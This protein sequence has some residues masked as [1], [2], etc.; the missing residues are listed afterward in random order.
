MKVNDGIVL[1][2]D[3][4]STLLGEGGV[5]NVYNYAHKIFNLH[6][7]KPI[8]GM[9]WGHGSIGNISISTLTKDLRD[10]FMGKI[11]EYRDWRIDDDYTI[12]EIA[13]L[14]REFLYEEKYLSVFGEA[15]FK[16]GIGFNVAGYS[17]RAD[18]PEVWDISIDEGGDCPQP[19][20]RNSRDDMGVSWAGE[21]DILCRIIHGYSSDLPYLLMELGVEE[22]Q[23]SS[24]VQVLQEQ[25]AADIAFGPMPIQ[26]AIDLGNFLVDTA[27]KFHRFKAGA[28]TVGGPIDVAAIT[29][30]EGFKWVKRKLY[31]D[32][33][34]NPEEK[35]ES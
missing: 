29:K 2:S 17:S 30:H 35:Y 27:V 19:S 31:Y 18:S 15:E 16:P 28:P 4:A 6:K 11:P 26:D 9:T 21:I 1:A 23:L 24:L 13:Q 8:G 25:L 10:R 12:E 14:T 5:I 3:S 34:L 33:E 22:D 32:R 7:G 20:L